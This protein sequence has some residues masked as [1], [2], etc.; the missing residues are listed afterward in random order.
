MDP[1]AGF[2]EGNLLGSDGFSDAVSFSAGRVRHQ[3]HRLQNCCQNSKNIHE[4]LL[5]VR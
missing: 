2:N 1:P 3:L 5:G 4:E